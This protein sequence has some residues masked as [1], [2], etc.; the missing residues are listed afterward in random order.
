MIT[1]AELTRVLAYDEHTGL[2]TW[3]VQKSKRLNVGQ[4]A[5]TLS[6][7]GYFLISFDA[8]KYQSHRLAWFYV[9]GVWPSVVDHINGD[10]LDN[11]IC[12][13]RD[14]SVSVNCQNLHRATVNSKVGVLGVVQR[15]NGKFVANIRPPG[16]RPKYLGQFATA[17]EAGAAYLTAKKAL[18]SEAIGAA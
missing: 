10:P 7:R 15:P 9:H 2:F 5:G 11:R 3:R 4:Q 18:H 14:V 13:L 1:H 8:K 6:N 16:G 17:D 12:N